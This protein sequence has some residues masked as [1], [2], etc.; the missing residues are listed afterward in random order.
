MYLARQAVGQHD[1]WAVMIISRTPFRISLFGG[2]TDY[3]AWFREHG[4]AVIG[5]TID[6]YS[7][8]TLRQLPPFFAHKSRIVYSQIELVRDN[9]EVRHPAV[10]G[11][12][13]DKGITE[14]LEIHHDADLPA[15]S[16]LGSSSS[17]TVGL[18]HALY[19]LDGRMIGKRELGME[20]IRIEQ[21]VLKES[22]GCQDQLWAAFGGLNHIE[23]LRDGEFAVSPIIL[24]AGRRE[25]LRRSL[26]L[27]FTGFS[28]FASDF[29]QDQVK[30]ISQRKT[31]LHAIRGMVNSAIDV[32][33]DV[34]TPIGEI[35]KLLH[36]SWMF[37][38]EL[39]DSVS[40]SQIDEI[41]EAGCAAGAIGGKLL[42]A[43]GGGFMVFVV[44]PERREAVRE[45]LK[46][47]IHVSFDFDTEGSKI[48]LYQPK[49]P[50]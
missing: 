21:N 40:N 8:L 10:R 6:K 24:P 17:F 37:K 9:S 15:R 23:F 18:L 26:M 2:G 29:A 50:N 11:V 36:Q 7:Y 25:E 43:G 22:V 41:Y 19:A 1:K 28:R 39:A 5:T 35:G 31:Q 48:V 3:P 14:G 20:A 32:L 30:N 38:R 13:A 27:F 49:V 4:G 42:G 45:K 47:L 16:G 12:L 46:K 34:R 44:E 33:R